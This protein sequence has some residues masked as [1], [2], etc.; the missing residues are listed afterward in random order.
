MTYQ[1][2]KNLTKLFLIGDVVLPADEDV[3]IP[4]V[5]AA[6]YHVAI[7]A[8][9]LKL[10]TNNPNA[11]VL[12]RTHGD[13]AIRF[14]ELPVDPSDEMDIDH[15]LCQAAARYLASF[16]SMDVNL[17]SW[18]ETK[19]K[20][21]VELYNSKIQSEIEKYEHTNQLEHDGEGEYVSEGYY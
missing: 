20:E 3:L 11:S 9:S 7:K 15:E 13:Y 1:R 14:P 17:R 10:T 5:E 6:L 16:L 2:F 4:G 12:R 21:I 18:H 19:A 8:N